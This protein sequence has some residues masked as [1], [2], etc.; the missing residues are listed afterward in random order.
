M[1]SE[2]EWIDVAA[3]AERY[4]CSTQTI[5]RWAKLGELA[6][7][8]EASLGR[9]GRGVV[10][11]WILVD[12]LEHIFRPNAH[13]EHVRKI[14]ATAQPFTEDQKIALRKVIFEHILAR[15]AKRRAAGAGGASF[16]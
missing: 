11:T 14:R 4:H 12:D 3:A 9:D 7:R 8:K 13:E 10:K 16:S 6:A 1:A 5:R 15:E 2:D